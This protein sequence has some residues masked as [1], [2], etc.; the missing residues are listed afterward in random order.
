MCRRTRRSTSSAYR[1]LHGWF[2]CVRWL[3][4]SASQNSS[5]SWWIVIGRPPVTA[6]VGG[7]AGWR[8]RRV[9]SWALRS[10][11]RWVRPAVVPC[12]AMGVA[13]AAPEVG[14]AAVA[15]LGGRPVHAHEHRPVVR[16]GELTG[17][18]VGQPSGRH[19][20]ACP[21]DHLAGS[22]ALGAPRQRQRQREERVGLPSLA[23]RPG[24]DP[25]VGGRPRSCRGGTRHPGRLP[26]QRQASAWPPPHWPRG[27]IRAGRVAAPGRHADHGD[28]VN[29]AHTSQCAGPAVPGHPVTKGRRTHVRTPLALDDLP[30]HAVRHPLP[31]EQP[32][33]AGRRATTQREHRPRSA[34]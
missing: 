31:V 1:G 29:A 5:R 16:A 15:A 17:R 26:H 2:A 18:G 28:P 20:P 8:R 23:H 12:L 13:P 7:S 25:E 27:L 33:R 10:A 34:S 22:P 32:R 19:L 3:W 9:I 30:L 6:T 14:A 11:S 24:G 21:G 4:L